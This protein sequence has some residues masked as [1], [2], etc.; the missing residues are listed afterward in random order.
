MKENDQKWVVL[1]ELE[2]TVVILPDPDDK[3]HGHKVSRGTYEISDENALTCA[4]KPSV[5]VA[6]QDGNLYTKRFVYHN[7]FRDIKRLSSHF[8][9]IGL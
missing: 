4:C 9:K 6:D 2:E 3:P 8:K 5:E 7:S 1:D